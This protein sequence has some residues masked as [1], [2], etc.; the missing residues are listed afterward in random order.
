MLIP[1]WMLGPVAQRTFLP[2]QGLGELLGDALLLLQQPRL[3]GR[4]REAARQE[5]SDD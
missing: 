1:E 3:Q 4:G 2:A 5:W